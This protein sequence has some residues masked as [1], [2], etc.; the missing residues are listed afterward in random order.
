M[1]HEVPIEAAIDVEID[2]LMKLLQKHHPLF[3]SN[4]PL[5]LGSF[6]F[7]LTI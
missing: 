3:Q 1:N 2:H 6:L 4:L 5:S 7:C